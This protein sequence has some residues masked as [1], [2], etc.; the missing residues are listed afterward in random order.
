MV[1]EY[2]WVALDRIDSENFFYRISTTEDKKPIVGSVERL[3]LIS[4]VVLKETGDR[5]VIV[6]GFRR[7]EACRQ[8]HW[9]EIPCR[10]LSDATPK[11]SCVELAIMDNLAQRPLNLVEQARCL[12]LLT[13]VNIGSEVSEELS[14][15]LGISQNES[16]AA[17]LKRVLSVPENIQ[18]GIVLGQLSL[19]IV[20]LLS[21]L[22]REDAL[23]VASLYKKL[24]MGLNKQREILLYLKDISARDGISIKRLLDEESLK[25]VLDKDDI[26]GNVKSRHLR[27]YLRKTRFPR[28]VK[29]E[30]DFHESVRAMDLGAAIQVRPPPQFEGCNYTMTIQFDSLAALKQA[31]RRISAAM[32]HPRVS[33]LFDC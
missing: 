13:A 2:D 9:K 26:D 7:I 28:L 4:P 19:P 15:F 31:H 8:L 17:K 5:L 3:G 12:H 16:Y 33:R 23:V 6:S 22:P 10:I 27:T 25:N 18:S 11:P 30:E 29:V 14:Q 24:P 21:E 20:L 1:Y 32:E